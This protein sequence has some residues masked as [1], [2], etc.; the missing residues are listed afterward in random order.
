M[1]SQSIH[2]L[3]F[4]GGTAS[5]VR[6]SHSLSGRTGTS[7]RT[8]PVPAPRRSRTSGLLLQRHGGQTR[9]SPSPDGRCRPD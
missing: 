3:S 9:T 4:P 8:V 6:I 2:A 7:S 5:H 1:A